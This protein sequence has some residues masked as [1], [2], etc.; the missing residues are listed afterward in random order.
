[1]QLIEVT[2]ATGNLYFNNN[3]ITSDSAF[4]AEMLRVNSGNWVTQF[5]D[6]S[7]YISSL[8]QSRDIILLRNQI[9]PSIKNNTIET[10]SALAFVQINIR[11]T[12]VISLG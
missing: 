11:A 7:I 3:N 5:H 4:G 10:L 12:S 2:T 9:A 6:N 8:T 1:M